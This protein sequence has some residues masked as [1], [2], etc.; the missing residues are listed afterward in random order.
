[1]EDPIITI[2]NNFNNSHNYVAD[3]EMLRVSNENIFRQNYDERHKLKF[4]SNNAITLDDNVIRA[5]GV[6]IDFE[7]NL[8]KKTLFDKMTELVSKDVCFKDDRQLQIARFQY[9]VNNL[10]N[11]AINQYIASKGLLPTDVLFLYKGGTTMKIVFEKYKRIILNE[12]NL[13]ALNNLFEESKK[14]FERSDSDYTIY[15]N[16]DINNRGFNFEEVNRD[17]IGMSYVVLKH[18]RM[19]INQNPNQILS[20]DLIFRDNVLEEQLRKMNA[21]L[22][23]VKDNSGNFPHCD[24]LRLIERVIGLGTSIH[25]LNQQTGVYE[26][27]ERV[28]FQERIPQ[29]QRDSLDLSF[30]EKQ[31]RILNS[32]KYLTFLRERKVDANKKDF[33]L[34]NNTN[35]RKVLVPIETNDNIYLSINETVQ[36]GGNGVISAFT[37]NRLK[38]N[39]ICYYIT[40]QGKYGFFNCPSE[41]I[42][43]SILKSY[44]THL[45][46]FYTHGMNKEYKK[47]I[48]NYNQNNTVIRLEYNGYSIFGNINDLILVLFIQFNFP[49]DDAKYKKRILRLLFFVFLE[50]SLFLRNNTNQINQIFDLFRKI[51]MYRFDVN[52]PQANIEGIEYIRRNLNNLLQLLTDLGQQN[53]FDIHDLATNEFIEKLINIFNKP[54]FDFNKYN[55]FAQD[56]LSYLVLILNYEIPTINVNDEFRNNLENVPQ[57]GGNKYYLKYLKYKNKYFQLKNN[58]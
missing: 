32:E 8:C 11:R 37:L 42:D 39:F 18:I 53:N 24:N 2:I 56:I 41:L 14:N 46:F 17:M 54:G 4:E 10:F 57:I 47:Y 28:F 16:P 51:F 7:K 52:D 9:L 48:Y 40:I 34:T 50:I 25:E 23:E 36:F 22:Q 38:I 30:E 19:L 3:L 49:W 55:Q 44:S 27:R 15:I 31:D 43:V 1:M 45:P 58:K 33:L 29:L 35:D 12:N 5:D 6:N 13:I 26:K 20:L 21:K